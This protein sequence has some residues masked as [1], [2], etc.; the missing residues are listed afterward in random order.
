MRR[1]AQYDAKAPSFEF[2]GDTDAKQRDASEL[3]RTLAGRH[4]D[5]VYR[6]LEDISCGMPV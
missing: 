1:A 4:L 5:G 3:I 6:R 2:A